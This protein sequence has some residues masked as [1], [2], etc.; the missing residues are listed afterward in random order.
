MYIYKVFEEE[1]ESQDNGKYN[2][3]GVA[4]YKSVSE[5]NLEEVLRVSDISPDKKT[6]QTLSNMCTE[7][8]V[9]PVHIYDI[10][11]DYIYS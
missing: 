3:F 4:V 2:S 8:Q 11:E 10:I 7:H 1:V 6:V 9:E 5:N